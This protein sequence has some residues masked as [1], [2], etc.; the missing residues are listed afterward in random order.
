VTKGAWGGGQGRVVF[1]EQQDRTPHNGHYGSL[2]TGIVPLCVLSLL[3]IPCLL[4][5]T[6]API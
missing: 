2:L 6:S 1:I 5:C 4:H 3:C